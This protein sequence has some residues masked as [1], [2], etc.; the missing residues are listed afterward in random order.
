MKLRQINYQEDDDENIRDVTVTMT[1]NEAV[2]LVNLAGQLNGPAQKRLKLS[3]QDS[4]YDTLTGV[5]NQCYEDGAPNLGIDFLS[6][7]DVIS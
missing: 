1:F 6:I 3:D 4:L 7:N 5:F 2:A